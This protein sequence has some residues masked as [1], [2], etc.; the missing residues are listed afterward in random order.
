M[1]RRAQNPFTLLL[2]LLAG[3]DAF[4]LLPPSPR[5]GAKGVS[6]G[7][8]VDELRIPVSAVVTCRLQAWLA[9]GDTVQTVLERACTGPIG[10]VVAAWSRMGGRRSV[11]IPQFFGEAQSEIGKL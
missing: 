9:I 8:L 5:D 6:S 10:A 11:G 2:T 7:R 4:D 1:P 3:A